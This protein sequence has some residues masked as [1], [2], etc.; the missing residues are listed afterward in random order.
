VWFFPLVVTFLIDLLR[1]IRTQS[2]YLAKL[3]VQTIVVRFLILLSCYLTTPNFGDQSWLL[4]FSELTGIAVEKYIATLFVLCFSANYYIFTVLDVTH[5]KLLFWQLYRDEYGFFSVHFARIALNLFVWMID[6]YNIVNIFFFFLMFTEDLMLLWCCRRKA[7]FAEKVFWRNFHEVSSP[8]T[9]FKYNSAKLR[10]HDVKLIKSERSQN[11]N[12]AFALQKKNKP[13]LL[14]KFG[15]KKTIF[16]VREREIVFPFPIFCEKYAAEEALF[17][18]L[19]DGNFSDVRELMKLENPVLSDDAFTF[20]CKVMTSTRFIK[21]EFKFEEWIVLPIFEEFFKQGLREY[22]TY[23]GLLFGLLEFCMYCSHGSEIKVRIL[24]LLLHILTDF[25]PLHL[26]IALHVLYN[27]ACDHKAILAFGPYGEIPEERF[28]YDNLTILVFVPIFI[29]LPLSGFI[30]VYIGAGWFICM[31]VPYMEEVVKE[32]ASRFLP[33][34]GFLFGILEMA[35]YLKQ[36]VPL[37]YRIPAVVMHTLTDFLEFEEGFFVHSIFNFIGV[38]L[39]GNT[40]PLYLIST[41]YSWL[42]VCMIYF[43]NTIQVNFKQRWENLGVYKRMYRHLWKMFVYDLDNPLYLGVYTAVVLEEIVT[44]LF[45]PHIFFGEVAY[46]MAASS[47]WKDKGQEFAGFVI[48]M[49]VR[50]VYGV[51][52]PGTVIVH[53]L[54]N[55]AFPNH[56]YNL[57]KLI[58]DIMLVKDGESCQNVID[59]ASMV[60]F[61]VRQDVA[62]S[63]LYLSQEKYTKT[64]KI[65][66]DMLKANVEDIVEANDEDEQ[67][68]DFLG[69]ILP[70]KFAQSEVWRVFTSFVT[71]LLSS[72]IFKS[73]FIFRSFCERFPPLVMLVETD[74]LKNAVSLVKEV[75][76]SI[77]RF[78][79]WSN[80]SSMFRISDAILVRKLHVR[81]KSVDLSVISDEEANEISEQCETLVESFVNKSTLMPEERSFNDEFIEFKKKYSRICAVKKAKILIRE[82]EHVD[83]LGVEDDVAD[84][85]IAR[86]SLVLDD[87]INMTN[88]S[89]HENGIFLRLTKLHKEYVSYREANM[90][91]IVPMFFLLFGRPSAGKTTMCVEI[92]DTILK[93]RGISR[94]SGDMASVNLDDKYP[95]E[96]IFN[97]EVKAVFVNDVNDNHSQSVTQ[98]LVPLDL[99]LQKI[100]DTAPFTFKSASIENKKRVHN[101]IE[102]VVISTNFKSFLCHADT[103]KL[104]RRLSAGILLELKVRDGL[105]QEI[106]NDFR[107]LEALTPAVRS[108]MTRVEYLD[109]RTDGK[110]FSLESKPNTIEV[111]LHQFFSDLEERCETH[112]AKQSVELLRLSDKCSCGVA[113]SLHYSG[114]PPKMIDFGPRCDAAQREETRILAGAGAKYANFTL[115]Q[116]VVVQNAIALFVNRNFHLIAFSCYLLLF[117]VSYMFDH[118]LSNYASFM[119]F[120]TMAVSFYGKAVVRILYSGCT[121]DS[122]IDV[123]VDELIPTTLANWMIKVLMYV[124]MKRMLK[125]IDKLS[126]VVCGLGTFVLGGLF[127]KHFFPRNITDK[128][129]M[130]PFMMTADYIPD[131]SNVSDETLDT[132]NHKTDFVPKSSKLSDNWKKVT[133]YDTIKPEKVGMSYAHLRKQCLTQ[134]FLV[135]SDHVSGGK[136]RQ[137][138]F[139]INDLFAVTNLHFLDQCKR[140]AEGGIRLML[141]ENNFSFTINYNNIFRCSSFGLPTDAVI[142]EHVLPFPRIVDLSPYLIDERYTFPT[143]GG[144]SETLEVVKFGQCDAFPHPVYYWMD[145]AIKLGHCGTPFLMSYQNT[146]LVGGI[147]HAV[148]TDRSGNGFVFGSGVSKTN[149]QECKTFFDKHCGTYKSVDV[150]RLPAKMAC[151]NDHA[152]V[153]EFSTPYIA[154][155]GSEGKS[156]ERFTSKLQKTFLYDTFAKKMSKEFGVPSKV[157]TMFNGEYFSS[158]LNTIS[159]INIHCQVAPNEIRESVKHYFSGIPKQNCSPLTLKEAILGCPEQNVE[160]INMKTSLGNVLYAEGYSLGYYLKMRGLKNK[161]DLF[162]EKE[163]VGYFD[164]QVRGEVDKMINDLIRG[165]V[166]PTTE[167]V[168]KDEVRPLDKLNTANIRLFSVFDFVFNIITRMYMLPIIENMFGDKYTSEM[169]GKINAA[170]HEWSE[171]HDYVADKEYE[172]FDSD[173]IKYDVSIGRNHIHEIAF[174]VKNFCFECGYTQEACLICCH[175]ILSMCKIIVKLNG[176][177]FIMCKK[178]PSGSILTLWLNGVVNCVNSRIAY[179]RATKKS[180]DDFKLDLRIFVQG[181]DFIGALRKIIRQQFPDFLKD[182]IDVMLELGFVVTSGDKEGEPKFLEISEAVLLKR[183]FA[184]HKQLEEVV[185]PLDKNSIYKALCF[186]PKNAIPSTAHRLVQVI[187]G[188]QREFFL[189]GR[190]EFVEFQKEV[191]SL[192][193]VVKL[194][195]KRLDFEELLLSYKEGRMAMFAY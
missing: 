60:N 134:T 93:K 69:K 25:V 47:N 63:L 189:H 123:A 153:G 49:Y 137:Y 122:V 74:V 36:G 48:F 90:K 21:A 28:K 65:Y 86:A 156:T 103:E 50:F 179:K 166:V 66:F 121:L 37:M 129:G 152:M 7:T 11:I 84:N 31:C 107:K 45:G 89:S 54:W 164:S 33:Y 43:R 146:F 133:T 38:A 181:D 116:S 180:L 80:L 109:V 104:S 13:S 15:K 73:T 72:K 176:D 114:M 169:L 175:I 187:E 106:S 150:S 27:R 61:L 154:V 95:A 94:R 126:M 18:L 30:P 115:Y 148:E 59:I 67:K 151:L 20:V 173:G 44:Y 98:D 52:F 174:E 120:V 140:K 10:R 88:L 8:C 145:P 135:E 147:V 55:T 9:I 79:T 143:K 17:E 75:Y 46:K 76:G 117:F 163:G 82:L 183:K 158:W 23:A 110:R 112:F 62:G 56:T 168:H 91:R 125:K 191:F 4:V 171:I 111:N 188:A 70:E 64:F 6:A 108:A 186:E 128:V 96:S 83:H 193:E 105:K 57:N 190:E 71:S 144:T 14:S 32:R 16:M 26:A 139:V 51:T 68:F 159:N 170:S 41:L 100:L 155:L 58:A 34:S 178:N 97:D 165:P 3:G 24:P 132:T 102:V 85:F 113:M 138:I 160:R 194:G 127:L 19:R 142:I 92:I 162:A 182:W 42:L 185:G 124:K 136:T 130:K 40:D 192:E 5:P 2:S 77:T 157:K 161:Y 87:M 149:L 118:F 184:V 177:W 1:S 29:M 81:I 12:L 78:T 99:F 195:P 35:D 167:L 22:V 131:V 119:C 53:M 172:I 141:P 101:K 39:Q